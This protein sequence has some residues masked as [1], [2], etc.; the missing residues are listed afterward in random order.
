M[1]RSRRCEEPFSLLMLDIDHFKEYNDEHG[2]VAGD[3]AIVTVASTMITTLRPS[4][5]AARYGGEEFLVLLPNCNL[6]AATR[7]AERLRQGIEQ[8][9]VQFAHGGADLPPV[10][11]SIGAHQMPEEGSLEPLIVA[12]DEALYRAK[13]AGRNRTAT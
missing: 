6:D 7:V 9:V 11:V 2:H 4:D 5:M 12:V 8:A 1:H 13:D 10:T 3:A